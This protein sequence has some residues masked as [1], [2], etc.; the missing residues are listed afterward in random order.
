MTAECKDSLK[1]KIII[2]CDTGHDDAVALIAGHNFADLVG[3]TTVSGN[4]PLDAT[5][6]NS[7][8]V[9]ASIG[10]ST[11][12][13]CGASKPLSRDAVYAPQIHGASGL[14]GVTL[15]PLDR[16]AE[17]QSAVDYLLNNVDLDTW[18][19]PVG[20]LTNI[21]EVIR[22]NPQWIHRIAGISL[23]G[24]SAG[25]GNVTPV[26]EFNFYHDPE[27][28][29]EVLASGVYIKMC[30]LNLTH[31]VCVGTEFIEQVEALEPSNEQAIS[32]KRFALEILAAYLQKNR[33]LRSRDDAPVHDPCAVF[34][35]THP[36]LFEFRA[37]RVAVETQ[38]EITRGMSVID[39]RRFAS[40]EA[41]VDVAYNVDSKAVLDLLKVAIAK[42]I[43]IEG[44]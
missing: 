14:G 41:N 40:S 17:S 4:A 3:I 39:D 22:R 44:S 11:S 7:L 12:V 21:A 31:Q 25:I 27:A 19:V 5:T 33:E 6:R 23:M 32:F 9:C 37:K 16:T 42:Y 36:D 13:Y 18:V 24:G 1:P 38:G 26:T 8:A 15:P 30:G 35:I 2:D 10:S 28:A 34:A 29:A 20:P 43:A